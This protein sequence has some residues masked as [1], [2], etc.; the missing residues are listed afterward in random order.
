MPNSNRARSLVVYPIIAI[1]GLAAGFLTCATCGCDTPPAPYYGCAPRAG[2][3]LLEY[4][5]ARGV[6]TPLDSV[7]PAE[8]ESLLALAMH[9][10]GSG[11]TATFDI[12]R[13]LGEV[14]PALTFWLTSPCDSVSYLVNRL[15]CLVA[16]HDA[17]HVEFVESPGDP[18]GGYWSLIIA[19]PEW[20]CEDCGA[21]F[22]PTGGQT[23]DEHGAC[24]ACGSCAIHGGL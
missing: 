18:P 8:C 22:A 9:T 4:W 5:H 16:H 24:P 12:V 20:E 14:C 7:T 1:L 23:K 6:P 3:E 10:G 13:G 15:P 17:D 11:N 2:R 19:E 21:R